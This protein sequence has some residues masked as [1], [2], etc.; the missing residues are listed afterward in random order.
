MSTHHAELARA[1]WR[2]S[3]YSAA[4]GNCV[5]VAYLADGHRAIRDSKHPTGPALIFA[6]VEWAA[7]TT[8]V[9]DGEF[10]Y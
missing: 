1:G 9:R 2:T 8:S 7:F 4:S 3:R 10:D 6:S 5:E